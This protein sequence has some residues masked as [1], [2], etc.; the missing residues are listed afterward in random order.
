MPQGFGLYNHITVKEI[1]PDG[2]QKP[3]SIPPGDISTMRDPPFFVVQLNHD[4]YMMNGTIDDRRY[5]G[6]ARV[7]SSLAEQY[8]LP[9]LV[10]PEGKIS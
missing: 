5:T 10:R 8:S 4:F 6:S 3:V 9:H 7:P 2:N 1:L